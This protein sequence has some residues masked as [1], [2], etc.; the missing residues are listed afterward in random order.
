M[1]KVFLF[2]A[3]LLAGV[4]SFAQ[5]K[6]GADP[7]HS[8]IGFSVNHLGIN[9]VNGKF[10]KFNGTVE[11]ADSTSFQNA[12]IEFTADVNSINTGVAQ[13]DGHLKSDDFFNAAEF[14]SITVKSVSFK[15]ITG[16]KYVMLADVTIRN[17]TKRVPF[18][19][20]FNGIVKD[21]WGLRRAGFTAK[22]TV[23]RLDYG[24]KYA[25]KL[26]SGVYAVSPT[27][28]VLV[29]VEVVKQ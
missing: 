10:D 9:Y 12:K 15:K 24:V 16:N 13:R 20:T 21:P 25:D 18:D 27:V 11:T 5:V 28:D 17:T 3:M 8:Q 19:V 1:K 6:W 29:N 26:P 23:N 7:A 22:A 4:S 14:P 2:A